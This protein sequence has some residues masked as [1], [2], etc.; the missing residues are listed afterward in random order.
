[1]KDGLE[2]AEVEASDYLR[3]RLDGASEEESSQ[4]FRE[5][6]IGFYGDCV[7]DVSLRGRVLKG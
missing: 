7:H 4:L 6:L 1:M 3:T 5:F 2:E